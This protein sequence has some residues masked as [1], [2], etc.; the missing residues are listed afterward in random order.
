MNKYIKF[1]SPVV[2]LVS[3]ILLILFRSVPSGKLWKEYN[4]LYV[5]V[6]SEDSKVLSAL[7]GCQI[8]DIVCLSGQFLPLSLNEN[9]IE[10]SMLRLNYASKAFEYT[11]KRRA[12]FFD[13]AS[14]YRLYYIP[15]EYKSKLSAAINVLEGEGIPTGS[16]TSAS[17]PWL[18][19]LITLLL[20]A[21]LLLFVKNK[22]VFL[23][24][25]ILP[26]IF[27]FSNPFY[28]AAMA[29]CLI[30][31]CLFLLA[32]VW[33][34]RGALKSLLNKGYVSVM[35]GLALVAAFASSIACG[36]W[37]ILMLAGGLSSL[38]TIGF[39]EDFFRTKK[40]F[41]PVYIRPAKRVSIYAGK[42]SLVLGI[43]TFAAILIIALFF[44]SSNDSVK[45][46]ASRL[47]LPAS[48]S[49]QNEMLPQLEDYYR[50]N[51]NVQTSPYIS[52]NSNPDNTDEHIEFSTYTENPESGIISQNIMTMDYDDS[53]RQKAYDSID[54]L[55][56]NSIEKV[57]KSE[58]YDF[59][60]GYSAL[61]SSHVNLFGIIMM[62]LCVFI[63][64]FIYI[65]IIIRKGFNK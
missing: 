46:K 24:G 32:N 42:A 7:E 62:F 15:S 56:F 16:D 57:L 59:T 10:I 20:S 58:G 44:L 28:P 12:Y 39:V 29:V 21:M 8:K 45:S 61:S 49:I 47:L 54:S 1:F 26:L 11:S 51:W 13:K 34:R 22:Y 35:A 40:S 30:L 19:P 48:S 60:A 2:F 18:L 31:L 6:D 37:F 53:F 17:Y 5:P 43:S 63:L 27:L 52:L 65:C 38:I 55:N 14:A 9:S 50:W 23:A 25:M 4:V 3:L 41:I 36:F 64:L 33:K